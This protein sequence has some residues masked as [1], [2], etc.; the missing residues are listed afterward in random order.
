MY[1]FILKMHFASLVGLGILVVICLTRLK[2]NKREY[3]VLFLFCVFLYALGALF[4][5]LAD[6]EASVRAGIRTHALGGMFA[7]PVFVHF[8]QLYCEWRLPKIV[9]YILYLAAISLIVLVWTSPFHG[10]HYDMIIICPVYADVGIRHWILI[11]GPLYPIVF[12]VFPAVCS[13]IAMCI[14]IWRLW[15]STG[16]RT[17]RY[18]FF[19]LVSGIPIVGQLLNFYG[20]SFGGMYNTII[21]IPL[22]CTIGYVYLFKYDLMEN[23]AA[24][25][26]QNWLKDMIGNLS[27]DIKTPLTVHSLHLEKLLHASPDD[28]N[29]TR[30]IHIAY[31]KNLD[32]QRLIQNMIE[33]TRMESGQSLHTPTWI[34]VNSVLSDVQEKY[35]DYLD[36]VG[37]HLHVTGPRGNRTLFADPIRIWSVFDNVIYNAARHTA[38]GCISVVAEVVKNTIEI[39]VSDT[40]TGIAPE[41][42]PHIFERFYRGCDSRGGTGGES[43]IGLFIVKSVMESIGGR[44]EIESQLDVGTTVRLVFACEGCLV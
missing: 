13:V 8:V 1:L 11:Y 25:N 40:G 24:I 41:H 29:F 14:A 2:S 4:E 18:Q 34:P 44:V 36:S 37:L 27:H 21:A 9:N 23:E 20:I 7:M 39:L 12:W 6:S 5:V 16:V 10:L 28:E 42:L 17:R 19:V 22:A 35:G 43:G 3:L 15:N 32:L 26:A 38:Q 33:V 30:N 31:N